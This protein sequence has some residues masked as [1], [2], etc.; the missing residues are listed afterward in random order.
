MFF[1]TFAINQIVCM[2]SGIAKLLRKKSFVIFVCAILLRRCLLF[3]EKWWRNIDES[4]SFSI[5]H[6]NKHAFNPKVKNSHSGCIVLSFCSTLTTIIT[7]NPNQIKRMAIVIPVT[8]RNCKSYICTSEI[9]CILQCS[10]QAFLYVKS[11]GSC[12]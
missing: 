8:R 9:V 1:I 4:Q 6:K 7:S 2:N 5:W 12:Y 11:R 3:K 10:I